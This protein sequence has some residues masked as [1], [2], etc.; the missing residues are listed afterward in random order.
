MVDEEMDEA[1][2]CF[3]LVWVSAVYRSFGIVC[4]IA[5]SS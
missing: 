5:I 1:N 2:R 3:S 4:S